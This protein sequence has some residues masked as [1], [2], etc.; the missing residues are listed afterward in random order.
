MIEFGISTTKSDVY[1]FGMVLYELF[2]YGR[3]PFAEYTNEKAIHLVIIVDFFFLK[4]KWIEFI[5]DNGRLFQDTKWDLL[6]IVPLK[7]TNWW[8]GSY[9]F[10]FFNINWTIRC[11][12]KETNERPNFNEVLE[13]INRQITP[14]T[15]TKSLFNTT[16]FE[17]QS[18]YQNE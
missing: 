8:N 13:E 12:S 1:S 5:I 10:W 14:T 18:F 4:K 7:H 9:Y 3:L 11:W 16:S 6:K 15:L 17:K 2:S